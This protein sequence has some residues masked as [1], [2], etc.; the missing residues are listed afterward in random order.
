MPFGQLSVIDPFPLS[1]SES[2]SRRAAA[3]RAPGVFT[4]F[5]Q[6]TFFV[7]LLA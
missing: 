7:L 5:R 6:D 2:M 1:G 3:N 4:I